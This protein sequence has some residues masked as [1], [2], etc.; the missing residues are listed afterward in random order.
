MKEILGKSK[1]KIKKFPHTIVI[2]EKEMIDE[3]T[4]AKKF[5]HFFVNIRP[6]LASKIPLSNTQF[7]Q[8]ASMKVQFL[9]ENNFAMKN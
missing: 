2:N 9:K 4:I 8:Y 7:E 5:N 3:K 1:F 6:K